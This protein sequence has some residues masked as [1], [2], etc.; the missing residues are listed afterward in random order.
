MSNKTMKTPQYDSESE[1]LPEYDFRGKKGVRGTVYQACKEGHT[2]RIF[3][4]D[5]SVITQY[6]MLEDEER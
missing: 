5:G 4:E 6:F 3:Q 2:V 1:M